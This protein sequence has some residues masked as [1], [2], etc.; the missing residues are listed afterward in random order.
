MNS[1]ERFRVLAKLNAAILQDDVARARSLTEKFGVDIVLAKSGDGW[2]PAERVALDGSLAMAKALFGE[3]VLSFKD[4]QGRGIAYFA[5]ETENLDVLEW[6][7]D[8]SDKPFSWHNPPRSSRTGA[9]ESLLMSAVMGGHPDAANLLINKGASTTE[10]F[11]PISGLRVDGRGPEALD[12]AEVMAFWGKSAL[13]E[14]PILASPVFQT[15]FENAC[16][17]HDWGRMTAHTG[18]QDRPGQDTEHPGIALNVVAAAVASGTHKAVEILMTL[19]KRG[20]IPA[21]AVH[22]VV[23]SKGHTLLELLEANPPLVHPNGA[24]SWD[25]WMTSREVAISHIHSRSMM[26]VEPSLLIEAPRSPSL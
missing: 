12:L 4:Q 9:Y 3:A 7:L 11:V 1:D 5:S 18:W 2:T 10:V 25:D 23:S 22:G 8:V 26:E 21:S 15:I 14:Q 19:E 17:Q 16:Q 24:V 20:E 13:T 6:V